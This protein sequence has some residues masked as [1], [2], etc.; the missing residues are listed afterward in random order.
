MIQNLINKLNRKNT[1]E[2]LEDP[3]FFSN[4]VIERTIKSI[5]D[6]RNFKAPIFEDEALIDWKG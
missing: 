5:E 1:V 3:R 4:A 6:G 2:T